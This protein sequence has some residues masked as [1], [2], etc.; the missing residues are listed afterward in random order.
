MSFFGGLASAVGDVFS[1]NW[2][3]VVG[4]V[5]SMFSGFTGD[6]VVSAGTS[7]YAAMQA[8][9]GTQ[10]TNAVNV[11]QAQ[12]NRD[13]QERMSSTAY[14]RAVQDMKSAGLNPMLA[15]SQGGASSPSG[16][17]AAPQQSAR[18]AAVN[19]AAS[20]AQA[21]Q[22]VQKT[23]AET[24]NVK[25]DTSLKQQQTATEQERSYTQQQITAKARVEVEQ[26]N[27]MVDQ[28]IS[29][30]TLTRAQILKVREETVNAVL[31]GDKIQAETGNIKVDTLLG[32][33]KVPT[34]KNVSEAEKSWWKRNVSPYL[35]DISGGA[36]SA[37]ALSRLIK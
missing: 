26:A 27:R 30:T 21:V 17:L 12:L 13:F 34:A 7:A 20:A 19:A 23:Q 3:S 14:Q 37:G 6:S 25:A 16:S 32:N 36:S 5:G 1:G 15:Y 4:D 2:G 24:E 10:E 35:P 8:Y 33:L 9:K 11:A 22:Q 28:I 18:V 29:Q 31:T